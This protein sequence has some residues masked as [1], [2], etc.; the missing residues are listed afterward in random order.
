MQTTLLGLAGA[1][2]LALVAALVGPW[3]ID[4]GRYRADIEAEASRVVGA[5]VRVAGG[6]DLRLLPTPYISMQSITVGEGGDVEMRV[7]A[8]NAELALGPLMRGQWLAEE[9]R[10]VEPDIRINL[11]KAGRGTTAASGSE[12]QIAKFTVE[13]GRV[14]FL[15]HDDVRA[16]LD[17]LSFSGDAQSLAGPLKGDGNFVAGNKRYAFRLSA[18]RR[19]E[20]GGAKLRLALDFS[21]RPF[22]FEADGA[23]Y[24]GDDGVRYEGSAS[25]SRVAGLAVAG[26][27]AVLGDPWRAS[28][29]VKAT[30][31]RAVLEQV[32]VAYG[33]EERAI[34]LTGTASVT[35]KD[36][37]IDAVLSARQLDLDRSLASADAAKRLPLAA[38]RSL[39]E[40]FSG[41]FPLSVPVRVGLGID[42]VTLGG[43]SLQSVRG[44]VRFDHARWTIESFELRAPGYTSAKFSG[45]VDPATRTFT[46]PA[47]VR[48]DDP[49]TLLTWLEG[50][51]DALKNT[52]PAAINPLRLR[53]DFT[54]GS[55]ILAVEHLAAELDRKNIEG[56]LAYRFAS[57]QQPARLDAE[58]KG[59][60][61]DGDSLLAF[62]Q[63]VAAGSALDWPPEVALVADFGR[64]TFAGVEAKA[65][66]AN[67]KLDGGGLKVE[68]FSAADFGGASISARGAIDLAA[69]PPVGTLTL[70]LD[71]QKTDGIAALV[72]KWSGDGSVRAAI[73]RLAPARLNMTAS[74]GSGAA[75]AKALRLAVAGRAGPVQ[76]NLGLDGSGEFSSWR[77]AAFRLDGKL[78]TDDGAALATLLMLDRFLA[79]DKKPATATVNAIGAAGEIRF[80]SRWSGAGLDVTSAGKLRLAKDGPQ[81]DFDLALTAANAGIFAGDGSPVPVALKARVGIA[82]RELTVS[83][84]SGTIDG[85]PIS[86][87]G[88]FLLGEPRRVDASIVTDSLAVRPLIAAVLGA[89]RQ[90]AQSPALWSA[91]PFGARTF[92]GIEGQ[93]AV[94]AAHAALT[95]TISIRNLR[96]TIK[97]SPSGTAFEDVEGMLGAGR[98]SGRLAVSDGVAGASV[99]GKLA[100]NN[101]D[102]AAV[103]AG[104]TGRLSGDVELEGGGLSPSALIGSLRGN[105]SITLDAGE[106]RGLDLRVFDAAERAVADGTRID[107]ARVSELA[108]RAFDDGT[109]VVPYA[110]APVTL[111][112]GRLQLGAVAMRGG[113]ND[114][115][116]SGS[117]DL[118]D[119]TLDARITLYGAA[120]ALA[121]RPEVTALFK[122]P[123]DRPR[124]TLDV[125]SLVN[126]L[127][128][129]AVDREA[130]RLEAAER[131]NERRDPQTAQTVLQAPEI[132]L[133][134]STAPS[135]A[136]PALPPPVLI[137]PRPITRRARQPI[138]RPPLVLTPQP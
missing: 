39:A 19:G 102:A 138:S 62:G 67:I 129:M 70:A 17:H 79:F 64:A 13:N 72:D 45:E 110:S 50:K 85:A 65:I 69:T 26:G 137:G 107:N 18:G 82:S 132:A 4:W 120:I 36:P 95:S 25:L 43:A 106:L 98:F 7:R 127:T 40:K 117:I 38:L 52:A 122:G 108:T 97:L 55:E 116:V 59:G 32:E 124:R 111:S 90:P 15:D 46:G 34:N 126:W 49:R 74:V 41:E 121:G 133:P 78:A 73:G 104:I 63:A 20:D 24:S 61:I 115:A 91:A 21:D 134:A 125:V 93:V 3:F 33:P 57:G 9:V 42:G 60:D 86:G 23:L 6:I 58:V 47:D 56:R 1:I 77:D 105:G 71:A 53:G 27:R 5:P 68:Q 87:R 12:L 22:G 118:N 14:A 28:A 80:E 103:L 54:V 114:P 96:T 100:L 83:N 30:A 44:D 48:S 37:Q 119:L 123:I 99:R 112:Q 8:L 31:A 10:L 109:L 76:V 130:K 35:L 29:K 136:A 84:A 89:A 94:E 66:K 75:G 131:A 88:K 128:L 101:A 81:G 11:D 135:Q 92:A 51:P 2:I 113:P 16:A